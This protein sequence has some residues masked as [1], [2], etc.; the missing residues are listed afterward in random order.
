TGLHRSRVLIQS[1]GNDVGEEAIVGKTAD[2]QIVALGE[3]AHH[4]GDRVAPDIDSHEGDYGLGRDVYAFALAGVAPTGRHA[5]D[6]CLDLIG[7]GHPA[8]DVILDSQGAV[9]KHVLLHTVG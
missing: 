3:V 5:N 8:L 9:V 1:G 4:L 6:G 7:A 2:G